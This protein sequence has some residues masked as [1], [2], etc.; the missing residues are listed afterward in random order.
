M[1]GGPDSAAALLEVEDLVKRYGTRRAAIS[2]SGVRAVDG[3]SFSIRPGETLGL[4][5]ESGC[6]KSTLARLLVRLEQPTSGRVLFGGDDLAQVSRRRLREVRR[7]IQ[8]V[9]QDPYS[10]LNPR[11]TVQEIVE[12]PFR[13]HRIR[14]SDLSQ[15]VGDLLEQVGL[16]RNL[17]RRFPHEFSGGQ[18]QRIAI[19]RALALR[20][21][22]VVLDEPVSALDVSV[23]AQIVNLLKDLQAELGLAYLFISHDLSIV[24]NISHRVATMYL[25]R[26]VEEGECAALLSRASHPYTQALLSAVPIHDPR[27]RGRYERII[28]EGD[29]PDPAD[30]PS[31]CRFRTRCWKADAVCAELSPELAPAPCGM[32]SVACHHAAPMSGFRELAHPLGAQ[33]QEMD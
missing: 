25:G 9:F 8:M 33:A 19:A 11:Y 29:I 26:I 17:G 20:P 24:E 16:S 28:L 4:V 6:G 30:P 1:T 31:G 5:G 14:S 3:V 7:E 27:H 2:D 12:E 21:K 10:S 22:L 18:R 23:Q 32:T 13:I 15:R